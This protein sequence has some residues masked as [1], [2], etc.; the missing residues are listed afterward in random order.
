[1]ISR[2]LVFKDKNVGGVG[3]YLLCFR[4]PAEFFADQQLYKSKDLFKINLSE[5][6]FLLNDYW[7]FKKGRNVLYLVNGY[8]I[9]LVCKA[10]D[11]PIQVSIVL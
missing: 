6:C 2:L 7:F 10:F 8:M 11:T 3:T 5:K 9:A 1:M 4:E